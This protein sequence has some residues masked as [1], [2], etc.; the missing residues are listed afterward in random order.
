MSILPRASEHAYPHRNLHGQIVHALG[1]QILRGD[2]QPGDPL[3]VRPGPGA[4]RTAL[5]EAIKVLAA[6]GLVEARPKVGTR[7]RPRDAWNLL[8]P[9]VLAWLREGAPRLPFLRQL[10]EVRQI[11][12]PAAAG[13]AATRATATEIEAIARAYG[14]MEAAVAAG[15]VDA[16]VRADMRFHGAILQACRNELLDQMSRTVY[17]ALAVSFQA[18]SRVPGSAKAALPRHRAI[19]EAI[20]ARRP[21]RAVAA[22]RRLVRAT[23][24]EIEALSPAALAAAGRPTRRR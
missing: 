21:A 14:E 1:R 19:L 22:M 7:V 20:R 23:A 17:S 6:K 15:D 24:R 8:D 16:F 11:V 13:L 10:T 9:D 2:L 4:S 3:P 5:R 12:E 18:T